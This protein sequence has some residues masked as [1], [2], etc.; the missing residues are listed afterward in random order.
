MQI[1]YA[2]YNE[3]RSA[4]FWNFPQIYNASQEIDAPPIYAPYGTPG[5]WQ[6]A[7]V[8]AAS[9]SIAPNSGQRNTVGAAMSA[10]SSA[11]RAAQAVP[12]TPDEAIRTGM[13]LAPISLV[14]PMPSITAIPNPT[15][16]ADSGTLCSVSSWA[17][18]NPLLAAGVALGVYFLLSG[19][20]K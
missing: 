10:A 16:T 3:L 7:T 8:P 9:N 1:N 20:K 15:S 6:P 11:A 4:G 2:N 19:G 5:F 13:P 14:S 17:A 12:S 18:S